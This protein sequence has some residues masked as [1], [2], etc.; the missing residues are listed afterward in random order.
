MRKVNPSESCIKVP[1][2]TEITGL[3]INVTILDKAVSEWNEKFFVY[4]AFVLNSFSVPK[5]IVNSW[6]FGQRNIEW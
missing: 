2:Y 1:I 3:F 4:G 6:L 5:V